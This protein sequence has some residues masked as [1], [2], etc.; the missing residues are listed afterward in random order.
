MM[1][2]SKKRLAKCISFVW[3]PQRCFAVFKTLFLRTDYQRWRRNATVQPSWDGRNR[4]LAEL[5]PNGS[6]VIDLGA[7]A[8]T[9]RRHLGQNCTYQ[10][11]DVVKSSSDCLVCDFN[12]GIYP[13]T[14]KNYDYVMCSGVLEYIREPKAFV[15]RI[16]TFGNVTILTYN[17]WDG[18]SQSRFSRMAQGWVNHMRVSD[19][20]SLFQTMGVLFHKVDVWDGHWIYELRV[21]R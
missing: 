16:V 2:T 18:S 17:P 12:K 7:G 15:S 8:Q 20:E 4:R 1:M 21:S 3:F 10:P 14:T 11:C 13:G 19:L 6:R 5:I 9:L